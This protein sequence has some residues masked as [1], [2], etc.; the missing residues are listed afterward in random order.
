[1][2]AVK[3]PDLVEA[4]VAGDVYVMPDT[5]NENKATAPI[6]SQYAIKVRPVGL[7]ASFISARRITN[8]LKALLPDGAGNGFVSA[9]SQLCNVS[10]VHLI[11]LD[12][13]KNNITP[14]TINASSTVKALPATPNVHNFVLHEA[15]FVIGA[16]EIWSKHVLT[17]VMFDTLA[18]SLDIGCT[19]LA[20]GISC[21]RSDTY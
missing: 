6:E 17:D 13:G 5:V 12:D 18:G 3:T 1:V 7:A 14:P 2:A 11:C 9:S 4:L 20:A 10:V 16:V 15:Q 8:S 21:I 19:Q